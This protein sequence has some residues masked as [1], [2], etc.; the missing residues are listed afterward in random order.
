VLAMT[1]FDA[2]GPDLGFVPFGLTTPE[3]AAVMGALGAR[4][5]VMLDGGISAQVL[6]RTGVAGGEERWPG[7][8]DV[9]LAMVLTRR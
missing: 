6:L 2:L 7:L 4:D 5:A 1:R 8:R 9:P 3:M